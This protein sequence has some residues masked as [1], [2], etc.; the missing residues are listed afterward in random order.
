MALAPAQVAAMR[1]RRAEGE[2]LEE[3]GAVFGVD[4]SR[5]SQICRGIRPREV[6]PPRSGGVRFR[7]GA[8]TTSDRQVLKSLRAQAPNLWPGGPRVLD[9]R[10]CDRPFTSA[11][12]DNRLC[13]G[14]RAAGE[15]IDRGVYALYERLTSEL[16]RRRDDDGDSGID[17]RAASELADTE[18]ENG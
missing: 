9:C 5:V 13:D 16:K 4:G 11:S 6:R 10:R 2:K 8:L 14:C 18:A 7:T 3:L 12:K 17:D 15:Q 1:A